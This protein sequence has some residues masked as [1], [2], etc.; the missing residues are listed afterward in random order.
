LAV[1][2]TKLSPLR[3]SRLELNARCLWHS[4]AHRWTPGHP[5]WKRW[6]FARGI[7]GIK[8]DYEED[9]KTALLK[10]RGIIK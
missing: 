10:A 3:V 9:F 4:R 8:K 6:G 5:H 1:F 7:P 2:S